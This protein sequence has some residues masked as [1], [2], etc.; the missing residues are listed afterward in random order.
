VLVD[1]VESKNYV[2]WKVD[3]IKLMRERSE[4]RAFREV[5]NPAPGNAQ[6]R[7]NTN[8]AIAGGRLTPTTDGAGKLARRPPPQAES[9]PT[10]SADELFPP[11]QGD[12]E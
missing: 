3:Y 4:I 5:A 11:M 10:V 7:S 1:M 2:A 9:D 8:L 6:A 12:D